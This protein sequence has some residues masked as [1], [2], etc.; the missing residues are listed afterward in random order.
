MDDN[1]DT[2]TLDSKWTVVDGSS[3]T[4]DLLATSMATPTYDLASM[5][6]HL[7]IQMEN[8]RVSLRQDYTLQDGYSVVMKLHP[9][10][11]SSSNDISEVVVGISLNTSDTAPDGTTTNGFI[12][13]V[14]DSTLDG[15]RIYGHYK[16]SSASDN[17]AIGDAGDECNF[18]GGTV[19]LRIARNGSSYAWLTSFDGVSWVPMKSAITP[20]TIYT[21]VWV[22][23]Y[24]G[25]ATGS[26]ILP[27]QLIDWIKEI[28]NS[29]FDVRG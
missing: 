16:T 29:T 28:D 11:N 7:A 13:L 21:N 6:D 19:Y 15:W 24:S 12:R 18:N 23:A 10:V 4:V 20:P 3:G 27:V 22:H 25:L 1:F 9:A 14:F 5:S 2:G 26:K 8:N 17:T